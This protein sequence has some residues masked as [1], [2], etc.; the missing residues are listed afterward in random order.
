[1]MPKGTT[2]DV[3]AEVR[4]RIKDLAPGG[5]YILGAVH[6]IQPDVP[7][8]NILAMYEAAKEYGKYPISPD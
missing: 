2:D 3:K 1:V 7:V 8:E 4:R 6:N 5:G